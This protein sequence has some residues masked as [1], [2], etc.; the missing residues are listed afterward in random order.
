MRPSLAWTA[1][2][3][4][5]DRFRRDAPEV[6]VAGPNSPVFRPSC[7]ERGAEQT[8]PA[9]FYGS[10]AAVAFQFENHPRKIMKNQIPPEHPDNMAARM[11]ADHNKGRTLALLSNGVREAVEKSLL[12]GKASTVTLKLKFK[13]ST[14]ADAMALTVAADVDVKT[15]RPDSPASIF[16]ADA[17]HN[18]SRTDP[19]QPEFPQIMLVADHAQP[20]PVDRKTVSAGQ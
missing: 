3:F 8:A 17:Q 14:T 1:G 13:P 5:R 4:P 19:Q 15:P 2:P 10:P 12:M 7:G 6:V 11:L 18:L 9:Q 16:F 20:A